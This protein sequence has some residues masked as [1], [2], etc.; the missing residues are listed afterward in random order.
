MYTFWAADED[1]NVLAKIVP[2]VELLRKLFGSDCFAKTIECDSDCTGE[3]LGEQRFAFFFECAINICM[4]VTSYC[5]NFCEF[6]TVISRHTL[7][8]G[9]NT[10]SDPRWHACADSNDINLHQWPFR[11]LAQ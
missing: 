3:A 9:I 7:L 1:I 8:V 2:F 4:F 11:E 6:N 10:V 5:R